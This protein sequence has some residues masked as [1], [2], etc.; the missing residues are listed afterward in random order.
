[1]SASLA[2][3]LAGDEPL[4]VQAK[5]A[6]V[7]TDLHLS[8]E[9]PFEIQVFVSSL[10]ALAG[11]ADALIILGDL[12]DA[13][14]GR[15]DFV[16]PDFD[17]L[18]AAIQYLKSHGCPTFLVR[19]NR[20]VMLNASDGRNLGFTVVDSILLEQID[21][22]RVLLTHGD[23]FCLADLPYQRLRRILRFPGVRPMLRSL[24]HWAR[25]RIARRMRG[26]SKQEVARKPLDSMALTLEQVATTMSEY[27]VSLAVIGHLH[28]FARHDLGGGR[29]LLVLPAWTPGTLPQF[30]PGMLDETI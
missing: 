28:A 12:F 16:H 19:G 30:V 27:E 11:T 22:P 6:A 24:P 13:Y 2:R 8:G 1:M 15:E 9:N 5:A 4:V 26:Y 3:Y 25:R 29:T 21:G 18:R 20:D 7:V 10:A 23:A 17:H 14:T